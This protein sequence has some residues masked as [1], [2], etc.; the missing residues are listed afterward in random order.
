VV[1]YLYMKQSWW[2]CGWLLILC[3]GVGVGA[4]IYSEQQAAVQDASSVDMVAHNQFFATNPDFAAVAIYF[5]DLARRAGGAQ[6]F[7][8]LRQAKFAGPMDTH[9]LGHYIG[10]VLY[11]QEGFAGMRYCDATADYAC[12][13]ALVTSALVEDGP[14]VFET[15]HEVCAAIGE[16]GSY[17]F[18][19]HGFGHGV[20][21]YTEFNLPEA[22]E[23]CSL[24]GT[25]GNG[26]WEAQ[27]CI[28]GVIME[29]DGGL[30]NPEL[31]AE[32]GQPYLDPDNPLALCQ[33]SYMTSEYRPMCYLYSVPFILDHEAVAG[34]WDASSFPAALAWCETIEDA[35]E[36]SGCY[37]GFGMQL[38]NIA[39]GYDPRQRRHVTT[40]HADLVHQWCGA[41]ESEAGYLD[42][43]EYA[44]LTVYQAG[45]MGSAGALTLCGQSPTQAVADRCYASL[46]SAANLFYGPGTY[47][48]EF[49]AAVPAARSAACNAAFSN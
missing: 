34:R 30:H 38:Q 18:C 49:C 19:F 25:E 32:K 35:T 24:V 2:Y 41:A 20:L 42:C 44:A 39:L 46:F 36:R 47:Q 48:Q 13:H 21:A 31:W 4:S 1:H 15:I 37:R 6:A 3:I 40:E 45:G 12:A 29:M 27:E 9:T 10:D 7:A 11:Q 16:P 33:A 26:N 5:E 23:L 8:V 14:A 43:L 22:I 17:D 28:G